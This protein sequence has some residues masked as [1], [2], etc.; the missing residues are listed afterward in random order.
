M[1]VSA[2]NTKVVY[3][4][5]G[6][7]INWPFS[8]KVPDTDS[9]TVT[10][11][12]NSVVPITYTVLPLSSY[13]V[14][15]IGADSGSVTYPIDDNPPISADYDLWIERTVAYT[16]P[17]DLINQDN[18][19]PEVVENMVDRVVMQVQ[20]LDARTTA[21]GDLSEAVDQAE[22]YAAS[23]T[24]AAL[25]AQN[26][27]NTAET[28]AIVSA[29][30]AS[31]AADSATAA[32]TSETH[33][34]SSAT[35]AAASESAAANSATEA[36]AFASAANTSETNAAASAS[37]AATSETN[38]GNAESAASTSAT[39]ATGSATAAADSAAAAAASAASIAPATFVTRDGTQGMLAALLMTEIATP[40]TP[41]SGLLKLYPK[42][43]KK[44]YSLDDTGNETELG[45]GAGWKLPNYVTAEDY[46][47]VGDG[48]T[49]DGPAINAALADVG[50]GGVVWLLNKVYATEETI[51]IHEDG[52]MLV[53]VM[54]GAT[55]SVSPTTTQGSVLKWT[56]ASAGT[57]CYFGCDPSGDADMSGGGIESVQFNGNLLADKVLHIRSCAFS[58]FKQVRTFNARNDAG[59]ACLYLDSDVQARGGVN[60]V[61]RC[62]FYNTAVAT[63]SAAAM[64]LVITG[65]SDETSGRH[66]AFTSFHGLHVTHD[67]GDA[68]KIMSADDLL[69]ADVGV[70]KVAGGLGRSVHL[71][72]NAGRSVVGLTFIQ[73][74][75]GSN[76]TPEFRADAS[77]ASS[78]VHG[79][80]IYGLQGVDHAPT[81]SEVGGATIEIVDYLGT[82]YD[83]D[84]AVRG[85]YRKT[86]PLKIGNYASADSTTLDYYKERIGTPLGLTF[87]GGQVGMT[88]GAKFYRTTR[89]GQAI[90]GKVQISLTAKGT[91][92]GT[93]VISGLPYNTIDGFAYSVYA[94]NM[95]SGVGDTMLMAL[96]NTTAISLYKM[97]AGVA[98]VL[99]HADFTNTSVIV[100]SGVFIT[101]TTTE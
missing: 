56:G 78:N 69:F 94:T 41:A 17:T 72:P 6:T 32:A 14:D 29:A 74:H 61:Y 93:A 9:L 60:S 8:F 91:S 16:Q 7:T 30:S 84:A 71:L 100:I 40:G 63:G 73:I 83:A 80:A 51:S 11:V 48:T 92:T 75:L 47:A 86:P 62:N 79:I 90:I 85:A 87:G 13:N 42:A 70:S 97:A 55:F 28:A 67:D 10:L 15:G 50:I 88:T 96:G 21:F 43:D 53:G 4:G 27:E 44:L 77:A 99:T 23:A 5:N 52:Q 1:T 18:F 57:L 12:D 46:G 66:P 65:A 33:A 89:I 82:V 26:S 64:G 22:A 49:D 98:T 76:D 101:D 24:A 59:A 95:T 35:A 2:S 3:T 36:A 37:A 68:I 25:A 39:A 58:T 20:Q 45:A 19:Y 34:G 81:V 54:G 38:A 31:G